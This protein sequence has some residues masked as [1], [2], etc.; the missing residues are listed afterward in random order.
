MKA[1][2]RLLLSAYQC[3]PFQGSVSQIGWEWYSRLARRIP[4]TL[5][6]QIRNRAALERA[7]APLPGSDVIYIDTEWFAGPLFKAAGKLFRRSQHAVILVSSLD[8]FVYDAQAI[9]LLRR[10]ENLWDVVHAPT[11]VSPV[12]ATRL[13]RLGRPLVLGPWNGGMSSPRAFAQIMRDDAAWLYP[14]RGIGRFIDAAIGSS[15]H[16]AIILSAGKTTDLCVPARYRQRVR[17]MIENGVDLSLFQ[18]GA[19]EPLPSSTEPLRIVFVGRL[20]PVKAIP[21]LLDAVSHVRKEF[22]V[23][24]TVAGDGPL[25]EEIERG[26]TERGL[27]D[28]VVMTGNLPLREVAAAIRNAHLFCLPS[29]RES[30]GAVLLEAM[31]CGVP[32]AAVNYGGPAEIVDDEVGRLLSADGPEPLV[33]DMIETFRDIVRNPLEWRERGLA[34]RRRAEAKFSW[35]AKIDQALALYREL[36]EAS[37]ERA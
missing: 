31:A 29:V 20:I 4:V 3:A 27:Q 11:P 8:F 21:L 17:R 9:R 14:I 37:G 25:R 5:V 1:Q 7:G 6:T 22:P 24:L 19:F 28:I 36:V 15:K 33:R 18:L 16:A 34:G 35:D 12:A 10:Q 2:L 13:G 23:H 30:G 32:V 26:I